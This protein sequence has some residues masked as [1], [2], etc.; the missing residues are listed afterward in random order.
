MSF[1]SVRC[2]IIRC[3]SNLSNFPG[4]VTPGIPAG[5]RSFCSKYS[6]TDLALNSVVK[7]FC[8]STKSSVLQ[9][10]QKR[11]PHRSTG[12]G[13]VITGNK[14][15]TNAHVVADHTFV[16]VRKHGSPTKYTAKVQAM[17]HECDL[18]ILVINS[19]KFWKDMK[20]LDLGDVPS[21]YE[22]VSVVGYPQGGDNISITKGVVSRVEVT[23]Y[24]H[25]QSKLMTTQIDAA[26][27]PG[28]SGGPVIMDNKV[29]G[30]AFQGLSRSQNT[31]YI[32][33][34]P[35]VNHF[36]TSV[37]ENGQFVGFCSLG[38]TCQHMENTH[39][40][41]HFKMSPKMTGIR[42]RKINR[43]S[44]AYNILKK[45]DILL[46]IDGVPI[47]NDETVIFRKKE[48]INFS[49]LVSMKKPG[50]KTSLKVLREGKK[51][52]FNINI[53]PVESLLPVYQFDKLPSYYIF[54]GFVFLPFTKPYLDCSYNMCDCALKHMPKKPGEQI[55]IISQVLEADVSVGYA[56]LTDLQVKKV[57]GVQVEN[58][59]H[60]CQLIEGCCSEDLRLDLEGAFA[61][62]LNQ[63]YAKKA[64]AKIL[65]RY[66]IPSAMSKDLRS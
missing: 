19:K 48:R 44:S 41:N 54:A 47:E 3:S 50:E 56:N 66:G 15:L 62:T 58:L 37:E 35:V 14:I 5:F 36:L 10:W 20:P 27:N 17:G 11:L 61:I 52:E 29:V 55:V 39:F 64:T 53:T 21:L 13:F 6:V 34:T 26:I 59:K 25:S 23:K 45:D 32:I 16:Q 28:N 63:N 57:N 12:S 22:T 42:I 1:G 38:I 60:L 2:L 51:H 18:A 8:R 7:V 30:V 43:S 40:R 49:H 33:P 31:G 9:P 24:S 46:A 4:T 65:K